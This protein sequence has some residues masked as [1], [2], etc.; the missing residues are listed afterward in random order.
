MDIQFS[1][2]AKT[3]ADLNKWEALQ[4]FCEE[5]LA[6]EPN[7]EYAIYFLALSFQAL[8]N[9]K[10]A[11]DLIESNLLN[12]TGSS[13]L[14]SLYAD[15]L[16]KE[17]SYSKAESI[18][19]SLLSEDPENDFNLAQLAKTKLAL[20]YYKEAISLAR[21][22]L[23]INPQNESAAQV[24][25]MASDI[26][27]EL[28]PSDP[29][30]ILSLNPNNSFVIC[31]KIELLINLDRYDEAYDL[32]V[33]SLSLF[34]NDEYLMATTES[35]ILSTIPFFRNWKNFN[36][37]VTSGLFGDWVSSAFSSIILF[38][39]F[40]ALVFSLKSASFSYNIFGFILTIV[41]SSFALITSIQ[42]IYIVFHPFGKLL[43][44]KIQNLLT[45]TV[46]LLLLVGLLFLILGI[47]FG[48]IDFLLISIALLSASVP[49][50][51]IMDSDDVHHKSLLV[52]Y[53]LIVTLSIIA[54]FTHNVWLLIS[55][56]F[57]NFIFSLIHALYFTI[58]VISEKHKGN[59]GAPLK[60]V[61]SQSIEFN[62]NKIIRGMELL[63][64]LLIDENAIYTSTKSYSN[65]ETFKSSKRKEFVRIELSKVYRIILREGIFNSVFLIYKSKYWI[66]W[67]KKIRFEKLDEV[68]KFLQLVLKNRPLKRS[69][70][71]KDMT[72]ALYFSLGYLIFIAGLIQ[73]KIGFTNLTS[74]HLA[75]LKFIVPPLILFN[76]FYYLFGKEE[77]YK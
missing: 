34:P 7:E 12:E 3:L 9:L 14:M 76:L 52:T 71:R 35:A 24:F 72:F 32:A 68:R 29:D 36:K 56:V 64:T 31:K 28:L 8:G 15:I 42:R 11:K 73:D 77:I 16:L 26:S 59:D 54:L 62:E 25:I 30:T 39:I 46:L 23:S 6:S 48:E 20:L 45:Y 69:S 38:I 47:V 75:L 37:K 1:L 18:W 53:L 33:N 27:G 74:N 43:L 5:K 10:S 44:N 19:E 13:D 66:P 4:K 63:E 50:V 17:K 41:V 67:F 40:I 49:V 60:P 2:K 22:S 55:C 70:S 51:Y 57:L 21:K 65:I 61:Q 58:I